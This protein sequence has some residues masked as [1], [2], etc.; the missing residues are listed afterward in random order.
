VRLGLDRTCHRC[1]LEQ[2]DDDTGLKRLAD[3]SQEEYVKSVNELKQLLMS[4]WL[5]D[6]RV[7]ALKVSDSAMG[8]KSTR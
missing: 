5:A 2:L 7:Q 3:L 1:R 4:S 6:R 8:E